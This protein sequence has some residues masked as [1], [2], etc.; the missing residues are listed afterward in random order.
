MLI[1][2]LAVTIKNKLS[3]INKVPYMLTFLVIIIA[4]TLPRD[5]FRTSLL[6]LV[7]VPI[8]TF[9]KLDGR[10][11]IGYSI[12]LFVISAICGFL[13]EHNSAN[14]ILMLVF[15]LLITGCGCLGIAFLRKN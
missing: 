10:V 8:F 5:E 11:P 12:I 2:P 15:W 7:L 9:Y 1:E 3:Q 13:G 14:Y 4:C 6:I